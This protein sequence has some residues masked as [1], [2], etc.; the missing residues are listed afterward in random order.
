M[1]REIS[2]TDAAFHEES[3]LSLY[4]MTALLGVLMVVDL[5]PRV[6]AWAGWQALAGWPQGLGDYRF[7]LIAVILGGARIVYGA[8]QGLLEGKIGA[9]IALAIACIAAIL[10]NE[11]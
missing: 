5:G 8:L 1:H 11:P 2:H 10:I 6:A 7:A 3:N 4:L 9:D